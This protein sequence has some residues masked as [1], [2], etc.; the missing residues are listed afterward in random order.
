M[1]KRSKAQGRA[2]RSTTERM[3]RW[4]ACVA[5]SRKS[6]DEGDQAEWN[7][8][9][10]RPRHARARPRPNPTT[11][12]PTTLLVA[13]PSPLLPLSFQSAF[14][15]GPS[16]YSDSLRM[17]KTLNNEMCPNTLLLLLPF[18]CGLPFAVAS[19]S[20]HVA[21]LSPL[22]AV[23]LWVVSPSPGGRPFFVGFLF[24]SF[25]TGGEGGASNGRNEGKAEARSLLRGAG[26]AVH[27]ILVGGF[28]VLI[29]LLLILP[30]HP[31]YKDMFLVGPYIYIYIYL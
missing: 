31:N 18:L 14:L 22:V 20:S 5:S 27:L 2:G 26:A 24:F 23:P 19:L 30:T 17:K 15:R 29:S 8:G 16:N 11:A 12:N 28:P 6:R 25:I 1:K 10:M 3:P 13:L 4:F 21:L 7:V 9:E